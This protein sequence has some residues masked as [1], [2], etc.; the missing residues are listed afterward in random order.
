MKFISRMGKER[1]REISEMESISKLASFVNNEENVIE[2]SF[3]P[4]L[5]HALS[6]LEK[7]SIRPSTNKDFKLIDERSGSKKASAMILYCHVY[8]NVTKAIEK[9]NKM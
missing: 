1:S 6:V 9:I 8:I 2:P 3:G 4:V 5:E 7:M